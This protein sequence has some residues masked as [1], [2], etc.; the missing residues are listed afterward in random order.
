MAKQQKAKNT[1]KVKVKKTT[2]KVQA[3][4]QFMAGLT[5][6]VRA[7]L[8]QYDYNKDK[9]GQYIGSGRFMSGDQVKHAC[10]SKKAHQ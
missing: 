9:G 3:E 7:A 5:K 10:S 4:S 6:Q 1:D 8:R 2:S